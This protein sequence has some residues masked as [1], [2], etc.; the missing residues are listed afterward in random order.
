MAPAQLLNDH[1]AVEKDL[2]YVNGMIAPNLV[3]WHTLILR[4]VL[5][6]KERFWNMI[7]Q[8]EERHI[9]HPVVRVLICVAISPVIVV[10]GSLLFL[11][12]SLTLFGLALSLVGAIC[13][14][15]LS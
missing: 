10:G 15:F 1:I 11:F 9:I 7:F 3:V 5:I 14:A 8:R 2:A 12:V 13:S 6:F 4:T